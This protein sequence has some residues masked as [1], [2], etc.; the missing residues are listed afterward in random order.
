MA[1]FILNDETRKN[2]HG[3]YLLNAGGRFERFNEN[4]VMLNM[5]DLNQLIGKWLHL[6]TEGT[7]LIADPEFDEG[8]PDAVKIKGKVERGYLKGA[9]VG[10]IIHAAE[11]RINPE[12]KTEELYVTD[13]ELYEVSLVSVPSNAG[14][15]TLKVYDGQCRLVS[16]DS[17]GSHIENI[18]KL[19][20]SEKEIKIPKNGTKMEI[21]LTAEASVALGVKEDADGAAISAAIV[22]LH[23]DKAKL[24]GDLKIE[25]E[26]TAATL[27][28]Q[29]EDMVNLA[30]TAGKI[31]ADKKESFVKL[32]LSDYDTAKAALDA[33]PEK[34]S[35][36]AQIKGIVG[37]KDIPAGRENWKLLQ[38]MKEDMAGLNK[39]KAEQPEVYEEIK[40]KQ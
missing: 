25:Q 37:G 30:V 26:K 12:T 20:L 6:R 38:W 40:K 14:A 34:Q 16:E 10:I 3:F 36:S 4:P 11:W 31:P 28:K 19:S 9:S 7:L 2:S 35:L 24:E 18:I 5:H 17:V 8:D 33:I 21:K 27:K 23:A 39:L 15:L 29:A 22:K 32:A 13:W 1:K